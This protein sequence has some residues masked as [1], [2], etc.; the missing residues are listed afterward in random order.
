MKLW[1]VTRKYLVEIWR[2]PKLLALVV[3]LPLAFLAITA[4]GYKSPMLVTHPVLVINTTVQGEA[5]I[6]ELA[7]QRYA[8]GRP[9]FAV[10]R[11]HNAAAAEEALKNRAATMLLSITPAGSAE[12]L[13]HIS[14]RGDPLHPRFYRA[15]VMLDTLLY[16]YAEQTSGRPEVI[17][18]LEQPIVAQGPQ[19]EFDLY[20]PG[21]I[22][23]ALL[24]LIPQ[25]AMLVAREIRWNTLRRLR[26]TPLRAWELLS[27][28]GLA[29]MVVA[30]L[31]VVLVFGAAILLGYNN[32]G[33]LWLAILV[34][35]AVSFSSVGLGLLV[36]CFI[37]NDSQA[38]NVGSAVT[39]TQ[40][41]LSG[42]FYQ[43]PSMTLFV[44]LG[45]Q[46]DLFDII[47]ATHGFLALQQV[48]SYGA[49]FQQ[50]SFRLT[51]TLVLSIVYLIMGIVFFQHLK[52]KERYS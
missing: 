15:S 7:A 8:D 17:K 38:I 14:V 29:Q 51:A 1:L 25:T 33:Q 23:F 11:A 36:A 9:V 30:V 6:A 19:T 52:M 46:I 31:M 37:E 47:P 5:L 49:N 4:L 35:L 43:F 21:M 45:H 28:I 42:A 20:A 16:R 32:Q 10:T 40:V 44:I 24:L 13:P 26:L 48:L 22:I 34:G 3:L 50:I 39:M 12:G 18:I 27:G 41:F 2:E